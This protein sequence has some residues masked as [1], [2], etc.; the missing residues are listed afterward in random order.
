MLDFGR[1]GMLLDFIGYWHVASYPGCAGL[2]QL[3][4]EGGGERAGVGFCQCLAALA[5]C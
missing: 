2:C 3:G 5:G 4:A 1:S